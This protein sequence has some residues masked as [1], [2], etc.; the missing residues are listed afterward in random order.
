MGLFELLLLLRHVLSRM[1]ICSCV[2]LELIQFKCANKTRD[3]PFK[4]LIYLK[5][6]KK[7][8]KIK[9]SNLHLFILLKI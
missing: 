3:K 6:L 8:E 9:R 7:S 1:P 2:K 5:E 4:S